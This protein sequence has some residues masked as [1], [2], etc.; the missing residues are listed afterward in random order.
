MQSSSGDQLLR[1]RTQAADLVVRVRVTT[2]TSTRQGNGD[3]WRV[4]L[5][6]LARLAGDGDFGGDFS[7]NVEPDG[8][9]AGVLRAFD[10]RLTG[11]TFVAFV[12]RF[13]RQTA[14][15][16]NEF[17]FHLASDTKD[18]VDSVIAAEALRQVR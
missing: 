15:G 9:S 17:H 7:V 16:T 18:E 14:P 13:R 8:P 5:R 6:P 11:T 3:R 1:E 10:E 2:I 12:R 4:G